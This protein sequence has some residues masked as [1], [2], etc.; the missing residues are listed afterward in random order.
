M[1][2][3][4]LE[5]CSPLNTISLMIITVT[6]VTGDKRNGQAQLGDMVSAGHNIVKDH[7]CNRRSIMRRPALRRRPARSGVVAWPGLEKRSQPNTT[8]S[9]IIVIIITILVTEG[10]GHVNASSNNK[11]ECG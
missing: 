6:E 4:R 5:M 8:P 2:W 11:C 9:R 1:A 10:P 3:S 7:A